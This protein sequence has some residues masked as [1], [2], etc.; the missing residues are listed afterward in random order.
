MTFP[1][2]FNVQLRWR[3]L[4]HRGITPCVPWGSWQGKLMN[5]G[6]SSKHPRSQ[7]VHH[8]ATPTSEDQR[9]AGKKSMKLREAQ[10][11]GMC[12][13]FPKQASGRGRL[14]VRPPYHGD[15]QVTWPCPPR[16]GRG[17]SPQT[18]SSPP[19]GITQRLL[20]PHLRKSQASQ[21]KDFSQI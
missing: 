11:Q 5:Q 17:Y 19:R 12:H 16:T 14:R 6:L 2:E 7:P 9:Q 8:R 1:S 18:K 15:P 10:A 20:P 3:P 21:V 13:S 4:V